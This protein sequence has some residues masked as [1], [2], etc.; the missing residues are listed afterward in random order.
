MEGKPQRFYWKH[1][2]K[3]GILIDTEISL[4]LIEM[5][6]RNILFATLVDI[7]EK[8]Q[9]EEKYR[10]IFENSLEGIFQTTADGRFI[11]ANPA[12]ARMY[13]YDSPEELIS[14]V[15]D[16]GRQLYYDPKQRL[17]FLKEIKKAGSV[18]GYEV[19]ARR[20]DGEV[21][22]ISVN[23]QVIY[24]EKG[25]IKYYEGMIE[26]I[27]E[28]KKLQ[29]QL[30]HSQKMEAIGTLASGVAHD[31]NN[32]LTVILGYAHL[33]LMGIKAEDPMRRYLNLIISASEKAANLTNSLLA[34]SRKQM[35]SLSPVNINDLVRHAEKILTRILGEDI[36][37]KTFL[38]ED[39]LIVMADAGQIEQV[40]FNFATNARD[41]M[42]A[43]GLLVIET[44]Q[45][46]LDEQ[47]AATHGYGKAGNYAL[48]TFSDF[49]V[50][51][52]KKTMEKIFEPFFTTKEPS[53]GT[54]LGLSMAY[55]II[56]QHG[57][58]INVYSEPG[59]GTT[60]KIY[61]PL[62]EQKAAI[63][64]ATPNI[65]SLKGKETI[66]LAEDDLN[67]RNLTRFFLQKYGYNVIEAVDGEDAIEKFRENR[68][69]IDL[70]LFDVIMP[71]MN[72]KAA[73]DE[74]RK[75]KPD[76]KAIFISG[77]TANV[78]HKKGIVEEGLNV[79]FKPVSPIKLLEVIRKVLS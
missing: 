63:A 28:R 70:L 51:M 69:I 26:E 67:I 6:N 59:K 76:M 8:K 74:I 48:L 39:D 3:D 58:H 71:K 34:F 15:T 16:I 1:K 24:D 43:G 22:W 10:K 12:L 41:A 65:V 66:L 77:Y 45:I 35:M 30:L 40:L 46:Y 64:F 23:A 21:F 49:G 7:T 19:K 55:G 47:Y 4:T 52:D 20:R 79:V 11:T 17:E 37:V 57:G 18:R 56:K 2:R 75:I 44:E 5:E 27:T 33:M 9:A 73:Y 32:I 60:F 54:G 53:K 36:E 25:R 78:I 31:F 62:T 50:G 13:G 29:E 61:L 72:G 42:P 14:S 68:D 38:S